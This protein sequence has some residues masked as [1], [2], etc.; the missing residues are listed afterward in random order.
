M[1]GCV[2]FVSG[3]DCSGLDGGGISASQA[4]QRKILDKSKDEQL[5]HPPKAIH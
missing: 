3:G 2:L 1:V 4:L 5:I